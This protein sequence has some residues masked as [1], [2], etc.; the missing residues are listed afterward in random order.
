MAFLLPITLVGI[1]P[2]ISGQPVVNFTLPDSSCVGAQINITNLTTGGSTFYWSFCSGNANTNPTGVN[3]GDPGNLLNI[4]TYL[5]LVKDSN[6][7]YCFISCQGDGIIRYYLGTSFGNYPISWTDLGTFGGLLGNDIEGIQVNKEN[8]NWYG[9]VCDNTTLVRLNFG[10]SLANT[11]TATDLGPF[12]GLNMLHGLVVIKQDT[13]WLGFANCSASDKFVRFNFGTSLSNIPTLTD[14]GNLGILVSP[15]T[16]CI[17]QDNLLWYGFIGD[18]GFVRLTFGNS[19][20]NTPIAQYL[21]TGETGGLTLIRD[22]DSIGGYFV[23]YSTSLLYKLL[24]PEGITGNVTAQLLG[25]IGN[26]NRPHSF[27]DL[28]SW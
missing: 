22:C 14:F 19:L 1:R 23:T 3:I 18:T 4:P 28:P 27:S 21:G 10:N 8:G 24:F 20:L 26:L 11:P 17:V 12:T 5:T 6:N 13:I 25:D 2:I 16:L 15:A 9:F 7:C